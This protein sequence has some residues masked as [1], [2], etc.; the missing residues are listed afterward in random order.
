MYVALP[1]LDALQAMP[2]STEPVIWEFGILPKE[3]EIW[4]P[5]D[6]DVEVYSNEAGMWAAVLNRPVILIFAH[7]RIHYPGVTYVAKKLPRS[8]KRALRKAY[9]NRAKQE[10][11]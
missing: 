11:T 10:A 7:E 9:R 4:I 5:T 8:V 2:P 3:E 6:A 1:G